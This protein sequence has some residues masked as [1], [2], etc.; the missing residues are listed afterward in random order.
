MEAYSFQTTNISGHVFSNNNGM[1]LSDALVIAVE[2]NNYFDHDV[3][4]DGNGYQLMLYLVNYYLSTSKSD[5]Q[6]N[7]QYISIGDSSIY[8]DIYLDDLQEIQDAI[9]EGNVYDWYT[10]EPLRT[11]RCFCI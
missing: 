7:V 5:Y 4:S 8:L 10:N 9:V 2:E 3:L 11:R 6:N 1:P